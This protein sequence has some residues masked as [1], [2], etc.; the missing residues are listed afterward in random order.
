M[1]RNPSPRTERAGGA[2]P[3][4]GLGVALVFRIVLRATIRNGYGILDAMADKTGGNHGNPVTH[5]GKQVR[6]ERVARGW[7][8]QDLAQHSGIAAPYLSRIE[9]GHRPP[10]ENVATAMDAVFPER[11]GWF[12]EYYDESKSWAPA[13]FRDWH[14]Y[15]D[16]STTLRIWAPSVIHGLVQT[17]SYARALLSTMPGATEQL[18]SARL[19]DRLARQQRVIRR[20]DPPAVW[21]I[22]DEPALGRLVGSPEV[23]AEQMEYLLE[24]A[25][26]PHVTL[27][28]MPLVGHPATASEL[29]V[30]D[31]A[32]YA[33]SLVG[34]YVVT[35]EVGVGTLF[36]LFAT[37]NS[38]CYRASESL[39][40]IGR[41]R[42]S[43]ATGARAHTAEPTAG[44][45]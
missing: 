23:M 39:A 38:E 30:S 35:D 33:E 34:G 8:L 20:D 13:G 25:H 21:L 18:I 28:V 4:E 22:V 17:E 9:N 44:H 10:T 31:G 3:L 36:R 19:A 26:Q 32:A 7:T 11:H 45:A 27:Q 29:I 42:G 43:W 12:L 40:M 6:K 14:E 16:R 15:E 2:D 24:L 41:K 1:R 5:F 37:I